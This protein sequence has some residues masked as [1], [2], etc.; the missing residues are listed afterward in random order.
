MSLVHLRDMSRFFP[1]FP[2]LFFSVVHIES[3]GLRFFLGRFFGCFDFMY[4]LN[5]EFR[6]SLVCY[7]ECVILK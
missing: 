2:N 6:V 7:I 3:I 5:L 1:K 4:S